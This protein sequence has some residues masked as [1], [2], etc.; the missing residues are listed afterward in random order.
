VADDGEAGIRVKVADDDLQI[1]VTQSAVSE[2]LLKHMLPRYRALLRG[3]V[4]AAPAD[5]AP[6][7]HTKKKG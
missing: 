4:T 7:K 5:A 2:L 1:D 3:S 6:A